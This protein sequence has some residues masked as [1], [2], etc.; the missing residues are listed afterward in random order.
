MFQTSIVEQ[1]QK[2]MRRLGR[3]MGGLFCAVSLLLALATVGMWVRSYFYWD[4]LYINRW[5][6]ESDGGKGLRYSSR[7]VSFHPSVVYV[8][9][10]FV[11][12]ADGS[13]VGYTGQLNRNVWRLK[14]ERNEYPS[15]WNS[16]FAHQYLRWAFLRLGYWA[17][18]RPARDG[19]P[20]GSYILIVPEWALIAMFLGWPLMWARGVLRRRQ[21]ER[22]A[23]E[24]RCR[25]CGYDLRGSPGR[26]PECGE[27]R[28]AA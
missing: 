23:V 17:E 3:W 16:G 4:C 14:S 15:Q 19:T 2:G 6:P 9:W 10:G 8:G 7:T 1:R 27:A 18:D 11:R 13:R 22:W 5:D 25:R 24:G 12:H 26:C 28:A 21:R 20:R